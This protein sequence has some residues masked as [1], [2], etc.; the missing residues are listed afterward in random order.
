MLWN[1][2]EFGK[3]WAN[4]NLKATTPSTDYVRS[5]TTGKCEIFKI[6]FFA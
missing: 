6:F 4:E 1:G 5:K 3:N 2:N